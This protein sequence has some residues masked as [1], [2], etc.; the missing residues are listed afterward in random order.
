M[1]KKLEKQLNKNKPIFFDT[2]KVKHFNMLKRPLVFHSIKPLPSD[3]S[4]FL[5]DLRFEYD[6]LIS[7][8][9]ENTLNLNFTLKEYK[10]KVVIMVQVMR[11]YGVVRICLVPLKLGKSWMSF[12]AEP[13]LNM[14]VVPTVGDQNFDISTLPHV[15]LCFSLQIKTII[16]D[17]IINKFKQMTFPNRTS[18]DVPLSCD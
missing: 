11:M 14:N 8:T 6:G 18:I 5:A 13:V 10:V 3:A 9:I 17:F 15:R 12:V 1:S 4:E 2:F 16:K 7:A